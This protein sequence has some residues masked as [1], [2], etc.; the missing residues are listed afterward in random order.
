[1]F[2]LVL[3]AALLS[4]IFLSTSSLKASQRDFGNHY[5]PQQIGNEWTYQKTG[6]LAGEG[7]GWTNKI[8]EKDG[9][10][11]KHSNY[12][13]DGIARWLRTNANA[14]VV[15]RSKGKPALWYRLASPQ[16]KS[17]VVDLAVEGPP[18]V[19]GAKATVASRNETVVVPA[20]T[21]KNCIKL[22]FQTNCNDAGVN[23]QWFAPGVGLIKETEDTIGGPLTSELVSAKIGGVTYPK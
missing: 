9:Q 14:D 16:Q 3:S 22:V 1:M 11:Y 10:F 5:F 19:D 20:G 7:S 23:E 12:W 15:E 21:F 6:R 4:S 17:W 18:C 2:R 8:I 13:G